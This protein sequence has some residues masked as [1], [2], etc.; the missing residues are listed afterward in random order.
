MKLFHRIVHTLNSKDDMIFLKKGD[1]VYFTKPHHAEYSGNSDTGTIRHDF[2]L[3]TPYFV[4]DCNG[5]DNKN[6]V[7]TATITDLESGKHHFIT[8]TAIR[9][10]ITHETFVKLDRD[11]K[12]KEL[13][14]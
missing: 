9:K 12:L 8:D 1:L 6:W 2:K 11:A 7:T 10:L 3:M 5:F 13:G 14:I 4:T